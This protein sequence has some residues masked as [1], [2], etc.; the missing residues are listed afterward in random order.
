MYWATVLM[1]ASVTFGKPEVWGGISPFVMRWMMSEPALSKGLI[2]PLA[3]S[4]V[5]SL[6]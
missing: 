5:M 3:T 6:M 2:L 1:S 4:L